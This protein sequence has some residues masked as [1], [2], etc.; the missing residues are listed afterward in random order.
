M[1]RNTFFIQSFGERIIGIIICRIVERLSETCCSLLHFCDVVQKLNEVVLSQAKKVVS[2]AQ[3]KENRFL[4]N[5]II[6][7]YSNQRQLQQC[8]P[9]FFDREL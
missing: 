2:L 7:F 8:F 1:G 6:I 9:D 4:N 3:A 5:D